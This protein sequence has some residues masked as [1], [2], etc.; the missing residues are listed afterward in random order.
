[1]R[2]APRLACVALSA[3]GISAAANVASALASPGIDIAGPAHAV[4]GESLRFTVRAHG[5]RT[6]RAFEARVMV[7]GR[8]L[9]LVG[10]TTRA[11]QGVGT[12]GPVPTGHGLFL[13]FYGT[14]VDGSSVFARFSYRALRAG[15]VTVRIQSVVLVD[16]RGRRVAVRAAGRS[17]SV[18]GGARVYRAPAARMVPASAPGRLTADL[19]TDGRLD[20]A[21]VMEATF[22]WNRA[23]ERGRTCGMRDTY[24]DVNRDGCI[25][26]SD[27]QAVARRVPSAALQP[28]RLGA[29]VDVPLTFVVD[30]TADSADAVPGDGICRTAAG[31]CSLR[32]AID[33]A[34][35]H[36]GRDA[37]RFDIPG[38]APH[39]IRVSSEFQHITDMT[40]G[41]VID[42]YSEP[43][44]SPNTDPLIS[45]AQIGIVLQGPGP[46]RTGTSIAKINGLYVTSPDNV[47]RGIS[48]FGFWRPV[49]FAGASANGNSLVGSFVGLGTTPSTWVPA[50][51]P[52]YTNGGVMIDDASRNV[53]GT[54][55]LAD[56]NVISGTYGSGVYLT[57]P[58]SSS[59]V[60]QNNII[61]LSPT[62]DRAV[63]N[64][65]HGV[66]LNFGS[67]DNLI[68]G[69]GPFERNIISGNDE[70]GVEL[71]HAYS[72]YVAA[73]SDISDQWSIRNNDVI[74]NFIGFMP[75]GTVSAYSK[76]VGDGRAE[77]G[78]HLEDWIVDNVIAD[79]WI[80]HDVGADINL[81]HYSSRN[82][83]RGNHLGVS[84]NGGS[85]PQ[86][87]WGISVRQ[88][89]RSN[90]FV[91][92]E[93]GSGAGGVWIQNGDNIFNTISQNS[94]R[95]LT[96]L[97]IDLNRDGVTPNDVGDGDT[98]AN[99]A[100]N[101]PEK[102]VASTTAV[103]GTACARCTVEVFATSAA[104]GA[105]GP[106]STYLGSV[107]A[108]TSGLWTLAVS[109][110]PGVVVTATS[111]AANGDTSEFAA[112]VTV[113][114]PLGPG[115]VV[116]AD[117]FARTLTGGW[118]SAVTGGAYALLGGAASYAVDG[119]R[120]TMSLAAGASREAWLPALGARDVDM[121]ARFQTDKAAAGGNIFV[122]L[123]GRRA[124]SG[125]SYRAKVRL[126]PTGAVYVQPTRVVGGVE[127]AIG[128]EVL[129]SGLTHAPGGAIWVR[130]QITGADPTTITVRVWADGQ[131]EPSTWAA[132][133]TDAT[134]G[135][136]SA[137]A[138]GLRAYLGASSTIAP[139]LASWDDW[140]VTLL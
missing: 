104:A 16:G 23:R 48:V 63:R 121:V 103:T 67:K 33:E 35:R 68:G 111:T 81:Q 136:Q 133:A 127:T 134:A 100:L 20:Q 49:W 22:A 83:I 57:H 59:N 132:S 107:Q 62:A 126:A 60:I 73:G 114:A 7:N 30:T 69:N 54:P 137:G 101:F 102:T 120:G 11:G 15:R 41:V 115:S 4:V 12:L 99:H 25:D 117:G 42:G 44:T 39:V 86:L 84:P 51:E 92:N 6:V 46:N 28:G 90:R 123:T 112:N 65:S 98:G 66:D 116:A 80:V 32:A 50:P 131:P 93:I 56:R 13:G 1:M 109:L 43:G 45:N 21:D 17:V 88:H 64:H 40:G 77:G 71:S 119:S 55:A 8:A 85:V 58:N 18:A 138:A 94:M 27:V 52:I 91:G 108:G 87:A 74:G 124:A 105:N 3:I 2:F 140:T 38:P 97:G 95:G 118:G 130:A 36:R 139:L 24:G 82:V 47:I 113:P 5:L 9:R 70:T 75:D 106:G 128:T 125:D 31:A 135:L 122:Y 78:I 89:S 14:R 61:G 19:T 26:V 29:R 96:G 110:T 79:N 37:I 76:N 129:V 53:I 72:P 34:N 10:A